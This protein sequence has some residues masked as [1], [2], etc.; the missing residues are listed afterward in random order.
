M[1]I[2][3]G[4]CK[5]AQHPRLQNPNP[6]DTAARLNAIEKENHASLPKAT[7]FYPKLS[8]VANNTTSL[9]QILQRGGSLDQALP[10]STAA[11]IEAK[12]FAGQVDSS[13]SVG[14]PFSRT[15]LMMLCCSLATNS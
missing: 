1:D 11:L 5:I 9:A 13:A 10:S 7:C 3:S 2:Y 14:M 6:L 8:M 15:C 4:E 12:N